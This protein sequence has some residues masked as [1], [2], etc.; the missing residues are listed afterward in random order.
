MLRQTAAQNL[1]TLAAAALL[2]LGVGCSGSAF[3]AS[4]AACRGRDCGPGSSGGGGKSG[5]ESGAGTAGT[6]SAGSGS[7]GV[8]IAGA[9]PLG[10]SGGIAGTPGISGSGG[11]TRESPPFPATDVLDD[12]DYEGPGLGP[13][14]LGAA[15]DYSIV[16]QALWCEYCAAATLWEEAFASEQEVHATL[17]AFDS[18]AGEMNLVLRAQEDPYCELIE[19]LYSPARATVR[20]AYCTESSWTDL[21]E[22]ELKLEPGDRFGGRALADDQI[23]IYVNEQL[24]ATYDATGFP[25]HNGR[26]GVNG[27]SGVTGLS[28]D[29]FGGGN[30][31]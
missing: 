6:G 21:P 18:D 31:R 22:K 24:V 25:H 5:G 12:F 3:E 19:L 7:G 15:D 29:D 2:A 28:W 8:A 4:D 16:E 20:V 26:I 23:E 14:W 30:L 10:G 17:R 13:S 27:V 11:G 1:P 9:S